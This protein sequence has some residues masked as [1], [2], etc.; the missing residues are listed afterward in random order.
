MADNR[1]EGVLIGRRAELAALTAALDRAAAESAA[2]VPVGGDAGIGQDAP[3]DR[4][5]RHRARPRLRRPGRAVRRARRACRTCRS[6]TRY[7][8][9]SATPGRAR[10]C[11]RR[12]RLGLE[13]AAVGAALREVVSHRLLLPDGDGY[14]FRHAL[15]REA[16]YADLLP[17][18]RTRLHA[19][20]AAL[21]ADGSGPAAELAYH[22]MAAHDLPVA[23]AASVRAG[24]EAERMGAPAEAFEHYDRALSLWEA[25]PDPETASGCTRVD[26]VLPAVRACGRCGEVR[27][28]ISRLRRLLETADPGDARLGALL[29][30]QLAYYLGDLD[31]NAEAAD[32]AREAVDML[33][34]HPPT[35]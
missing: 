7:G 31:M 6:P 26:L 15:L 19:A 17:G 35:P 3:G 22:S 10:R 5:G 25:V 12:W 28:A 14:V 29:R 9:A 11:A 20:F 27:R 30:E 18:E 4:A 33:P 23:F 16:V 13:E 1:R 21:L 8:G 34:A 2:T 32:I 24:R